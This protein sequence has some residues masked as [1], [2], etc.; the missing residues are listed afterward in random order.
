MLRH[1]WPK[2]LKG[3][4]QFYK[5]QVLMSGKYL[6]DL[7]EMM[8]EGVDYIEVAEDKVQWRDFVNTVIN[9]RVL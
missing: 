5:S 7:R 3:R 1:F 6:M 8:C 2:I 4:D 9:I